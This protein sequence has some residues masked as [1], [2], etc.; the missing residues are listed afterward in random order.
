MIDYLSR[1]TPLAAC[2]NLGC[3]RAGTC[4]H[5]ARNG[6]CLKDNFACE[7]D[8][9]MALA[10]RLEELAIQL[11]APPRDPNEPPPTKE[12]W[13]LAELGPRDAQRGNQHD[14]R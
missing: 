3:R 5:L 10:I 13:A 1:S 7:D 14:V 6:K 9:R 12:E 11:G 8:R 2:P 4:H